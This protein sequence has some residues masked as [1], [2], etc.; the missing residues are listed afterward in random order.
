[1]H[2]KSS[3]PEPASVFENDDELAPVVSEHAED[4]RGSNEEQKDFLRIPNSL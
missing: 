1:M 4:I 3:Q 2:F